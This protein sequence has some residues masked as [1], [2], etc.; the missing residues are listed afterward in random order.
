ML[1]GLGLAVT[2]IRRQQTLE[3]LCSTFGFSAIQRSTS[4]LAS[5][6]LNVFVSFGSFILVS[7]YL[8]LVARTV[9]PAGGSAVA[10]GVVAAIAGPMLAASGAAHGMPRKPWLA[11]DDRRG[12]IRGSGASSAVRCALTIA[13]GWALWAFGGSAAATLT[14]GND[15]GSAPPERA[16]AVSA[17]RRRARSWAV[18][19]ASP[20]SAASGPRSIADGGI[21]A[22]RRHKHLSSP[23]RRATLSAAR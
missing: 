15:L 6:V 19:W 3:T 8:Q 11:A 5:N 23:P 14:T 9:A 7:Q 10:A 17:W 20:C 16:G 1:V 2:F 21:F 12:W 4:P 13:L 22:S 18:R